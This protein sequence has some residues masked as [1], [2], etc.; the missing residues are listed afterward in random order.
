M[1]A[2]Q[3]ADVCLQKCVGESLDQLSK[4][5]ILIQSSAT[6]IS[7]FDL[8]LG[9]ISLKGKTNTLKPNTLFYGEFLYAKYPPKDGRIQEKSSRE[10]RLRNTSEL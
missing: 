2:Y 10:I 3:L 5:D 1:T 6:Y 9:I 4:K 8:A 7:W